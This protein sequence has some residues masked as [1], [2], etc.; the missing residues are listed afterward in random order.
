MVPSASESSKPSVLP[1]SAERAFSFQALT[2]ILYGGDHSAFF[3]YVN[4]QRAFP[5]A[6]RVTNLP[7]V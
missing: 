2:L 4:H 3:G 5:M 7:A 6:Q 1:L